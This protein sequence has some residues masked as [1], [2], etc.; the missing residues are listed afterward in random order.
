MSMK[1]SGM[2]AFILLIHILFVPG[3]TGQEADWRNLAEGLIIPDEAYSDQPFMV[4]TDDGA[5]LCVM[6]TGGG[7]EG[8]AGQHV[9]SQRSFDQGKSWI[10]KRDVEPSDGPE[11]SYAVLLKATNGR[12]FVFYN[13]NT[14]NVRSVIGNDPP[15]RDGVVKRV[16]SQGYFVFKYSDDHG[17]SWSDERYEIPVRDFEIDLNNVYGGKI[18]FFWNVGKPFTMGSAAYV[19][20]IKVGG[21]GAGFFTSNE[22]ALLHSTNL[23]NVENPANAEWSTLPEG[24]IG[25]RTP[26]GGGP[27]AAEQSYVLLSDESIYCVYRTTDGY[28]VTSVSRDR[29]KSWDEPSYLT[30]ANG[31]LVKNPRAANFVWKCKNGKFLYW[32]H[33]HGGAYLG[34]HPNKASVGFLD[35][36]PAWLVG[37]KEIETPTGKSIAWSQPEILLYDDDPMVRTS[38]PDLVEENDEYFISETQKDIA[39]VHKLDKGLVEGLWQQLDDPSPPK[40]DP[41]WS[42][43]G[44]GS[45]ASA[46]SI[47]AFFI[48]NPTAF[49]GKGKSTRKG[50][51]IELI[52]EDSDEMRDQTLLTTIDDFGRGWKLSL[53]DQRLHLFMSDGRSEATWSSD[54]GCLAGSG[55]HHVGVVIDGG[56]RIIMFIIDGILNDGGLSRQFGWGRFNPYLQDVHGDRF[57]SIND[58]ALQNGKV[59][60]YGQALT[61]S[62]VIGNY[63]MLLD[64]IRATKKK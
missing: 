25:L 42:W 52:L 57:I 41:I 51:T 3:V 5:W 64:S 17:K 43:D 55:P 21:F 34:Q 4:K 18:K 58:E 1:L 62:D 16:D 11:A 50:F 22:G 53:S 8:V 33:N 27:I 61:T 12:I 59:D 24:Q 56:P 39:R 48:R 7:H 30:F 31:R 14:D 45:R 54:P 10:D 37:G 44:I 32:F 6:T 38:Y 2:L 23:L 29:G 63:H 19:P 46:P 49:D 36:N 28:P 20:I 40:V 60:I 35:R 9:I 47:P 26:P 13:H 15:Y